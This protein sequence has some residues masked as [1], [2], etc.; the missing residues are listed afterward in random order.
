M[1]NYKNTFGVEVFKKEIHAPLD[2]LDRPELDV[3]ELCD[4]TEV[5]IY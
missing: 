1:T 2:T 5:N 3:N 4:V